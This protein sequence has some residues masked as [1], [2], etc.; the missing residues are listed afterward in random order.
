MDMDSSD[1]S[2]IDGFYNNIKFNIKAYILPWIEVS[3]TWVGFMV[4]SYGL[5][6]LYGKAK[7]LL[8]RR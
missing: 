4:I 8:I 5:Y 1:T 7:L 2:F 6:K 3:V